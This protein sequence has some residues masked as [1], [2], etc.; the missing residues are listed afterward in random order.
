M[1]PI[2]SAIANEETS[3]ME[4]AFESITAKL[5]NR[6]GPS[7]SVVPDNDTAE[8]NSS[9]EFPEYDVAVKEAKPPSLPKVLLDRD[10][11]KI[12]RIRVLCDCGKSIVLKYV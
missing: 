4:S 2:F 3:E 9:V 8:E 5:A 7:V 1:K 6:K 10:G 11:E 12:S